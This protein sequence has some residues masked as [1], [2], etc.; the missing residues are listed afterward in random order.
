[1]L[2]EWQEATKALIEE[3]QRETIVYPGGALPKDHTFGPKARPL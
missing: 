2:E 3:E 1:M